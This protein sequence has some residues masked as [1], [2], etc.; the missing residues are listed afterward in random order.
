MSIRRKP[1]E[2]VRRRPGSGF[3]SEAE[4]A[5]IQVP[6]DE[7]YTLEADPCMLNCG[8]PE[9]REWANLQIVDG[10][11]AGQTLFHISECEME[12]KN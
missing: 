9:C 10:E 1:G 3:I 4:P 5:F 12:S 6:E 7:A 11:H 8:D 2:I